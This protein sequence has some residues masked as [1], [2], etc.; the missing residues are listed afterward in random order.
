MSEIIQF[1]RQDAGKSS[2]LEAVID[3]AL[4]TIPEKDREKI[5]FDLIKTVDSY[6][7]FFTEWS[8]SLP[9]E[10]DE[11][12]KKQIYD[13]AHQEHDRK[14]RMLADIIRL[15]IQVLVAQYHQRR[16]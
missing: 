4:K 13:I 2:D 15:K 16:Y 11:T 8:L 10:G 9:A 7:A 1:P 14:M 12:L 6:D 5:R 3:K